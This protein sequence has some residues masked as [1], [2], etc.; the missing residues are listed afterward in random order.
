MRAL[1]PI[2]AAEDV[3]PALEP[4]NPMWPVLVS[5]LGSAPLDDLA[6]MLDAYTGDDQ[7]EARID[8]ARLGGHPPYIED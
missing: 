4:I 6:V 7:H 5:L 1:P 8:A 2:V 3:L